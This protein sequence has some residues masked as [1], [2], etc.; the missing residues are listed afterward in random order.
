[1]SSSY[2]RPGISQTARSNSPAQV[3]RTRTEFRQGTQA[4]Q[5]ARL[6]DNTNPNVAAANAG[7]DYKALSKFLND[8]IEPVQQIGTELDIANANRQVGEL[9]AE[10]PNLDQLYKDGDQAT[11]DR[12]RSL[13]PRAQDLTYQRLASSGALAYGTTYQESLLASEILKDPARED[14]YEAEKTKLRGEALESSGLLA[15]PPQYLSGQVGSTIAGLEA[16]MEGKLTGIRLRTASERRSVEAG[17]GLGAEMVQFAAQSQAIKTMPEGEEKTQASAQLIGGLNKWVKEQLKATLQSGD[18]SPESFLSELVIQGIQPRIAQF[19]A[20]GDISAAQEL[21]DA[22]SVLFNGPKL[23]IGDGKTSLFSLRLKGAGGRSLSL[24]EWVLSQEKVIEQFR[25]KDIDNQVNDALA[26]VI[27]DLSDNT[28]PAAVAAAQARL[29]ALLESVPTEVAIPLLQR[30]NQLEG[31]AQ[32]ETDQ[33][34]RYYSQLISQPGWTDLSQVE[35]FR[36]LQQAASNGL[37]SAGRLVQE[38]QSPANT[39]EFQALK[40]AEQGWE[41]AGALGTLKTDMQSAEAAMLA[42]E[43][44]ATDTERKALQQ[45]FRNEVQ[46]EV[47]RLSAEEIGRRLQAGEPVTLKDKQEI[48][49]KN[50]KT[51]LDERKEIYQSEAESYTSPMKITTTQ[52]NEYLQL[53][54]AGKKSVERLPESLKEEFR[55]LFGRA[56]SEGEVLNYLLNKMTKVVVTKDGKKIYTFGDSLQKAKKTLGTLRDQAEKSPG[57]QNPMQGSGLDLL[58]FELPVFGS[59]SYSN[60]ELEQIRNRREEGEPNKQNKQGEQSSLP[61]VPEIVTAGLEGIARVT[62]PRPAKA[63]TLVENQ[64]QLALMQRL[65]EKREPPTLVTPPMP[66]VA[67]AARTESVP[68]AITTPNHPFFVAIGIAEGTRTPNGG[69]TKNYY[70]HRDSSDG[71]FNIGTVSGGRN[72]E[73]T[74]QQVDRAWMGILTQTQMQNSGLLRRFGIEPG[75]QGYN[76]LMFNIL[77]LRVQSPAALGDFLNKI[78]EVVR[79]GLSIEAIAKARAD[80]F[81]APDGTLDTSFPSYQALYTDQRSRAQVWD[82]RRRG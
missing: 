49:E 67:A 45:E 65:W 43:R 8:L 80:S 74:P 70:G 61:S 76:R 73:T 46:T 72:G 37:I 40:G 41:A 29:P 28:N 32:R 50:L 44:P 9:V 55:N 20:M 19:L 34:K 64:E 25:Q 15:L 6:I 68:M 39:L 56:G 2:S 78:P 59:S 81:Y 17:K 18:G 14:E 4:G 47:N 54:K 51:V 48:V 11:Q 58:N 23:D 57:L 22:S 36:R 1:M 82:Y 53:V 62:S 69:F 13:S 30:I 3:R 31:F 24:D 33:Q 7:Q 38:A 5:S 10:T 35:R 66:Q 27:K 79:G 75:T 16:E 71:N 60:D 12:I 77:D 52:V 26:T 42:A 63:G 21:L